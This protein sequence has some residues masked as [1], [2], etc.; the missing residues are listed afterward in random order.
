ME[1]TSPRRT[2]APITPCSTVHPSTVQNCHQENHLINSTVQRLAF[3]VNNTQQCSLLLA[4][5]KVN[6][7]NGGRPFSSSISDVVCSASQFLDEDNWYLLEEDGS[8][9]KENGLV[10][11]TSAFHTSSDKDSSRLCSNDPQ[12]IVTH[13]EFMQTFGE[14]LYRENA[15]GIVMAL[16]VD[17]ESVVCAYN[18]RRE[19]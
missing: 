8:R 7:R 17:R 11:H 5:D 9:V 2:A 10:D 1:S 6:T 19:H 15:Y 3:N 12:D 16:C 4:D 18:A 14:P 13:V